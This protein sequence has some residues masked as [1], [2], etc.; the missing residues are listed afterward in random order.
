MTNKSR[1]T[2]GSQSCTSFMNNASNHDKW[3]SGWEGTV[4]GW[5]GSQGPDLRRVMGGGP[6]DQDG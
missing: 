2:W 5:K 3:A 4:Q 1:P 6:E